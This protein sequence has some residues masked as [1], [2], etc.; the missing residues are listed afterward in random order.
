M[1]PSSLAGMRLVWLMASKACWMAAAVDAASVGETLMFAAPPC[2][3]PTRVGWLT[4]LT[5]AE[6][7]NPE[8]HWGST[9]TSSGWVLKLA[10][11]PKSIM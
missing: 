11:G 9:T 3:A 2:V 8:A 10:A 1:S 7:R 4:M 5:C 6:G